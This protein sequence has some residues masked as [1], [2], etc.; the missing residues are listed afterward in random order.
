MWGGV[1]FQRGGGLSV[2]R[3]GGGR[4]SSR[5][6]RSNMTHNQ[7]D[8][9]L[10]P[11]P[12][13]CILGEMLNG[14]PIFPGS[15]TMNQLD[16]IMEATGEGGAGDACGVG[17][18]RCFGACGVSVIVMC[19]LISGIGCLFRTRQPNRIPISTHVRFNPP[20]PRPPQPGRPRRHQQPLCRHDD[21]VMQR[22]AGGFCWGGLVWVGL[23]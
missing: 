14:K 13:G 3:W 17:G 4:A 22:H 7:H 12:P 6:A 8:T 23:D 5:N 2:K 10:P 18:G 9:C 20:P 19:V 11:A 21:G 1:R 15:S 16:R